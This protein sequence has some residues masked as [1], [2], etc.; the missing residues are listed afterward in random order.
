[1]R[2]IFLT[3]AIVLGVSQFAKA[4]TD[5]GVG[6]LVGTGTTA[7]E[8]K[9]NFNVTDVISISPSVD[10]FL[11]DSDFDYSLFMIGVDGHYNFELND[12]FT[13][14][15]IVGLN[16]FFVS[17]DGYSG[18]SDIGLSVGGGA[19]Y[20]LSDSMKLYAEAKYIRTGFGLSAGILFSL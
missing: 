7:I 10:Y 14:Y 17:G 9:A 2:K 1:M 11:V 6:I 3:I 20:G 8:A 5:L 15:P 16:Y 19:T 18:G 4:Q 13:A 12:D